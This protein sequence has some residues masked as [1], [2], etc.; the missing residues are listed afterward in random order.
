MNASHWFAAFVA[1]VL[2]E[3]AVAVPLLGRGE[4]LARRA[5]AAFVG[6]LVT[7]PLVWFVWPALGLPRL[8]FLLLGETWALLAELGVYRLVF[9]SLPWARAL[10]VSALANGASCAAAALLAP[11]IR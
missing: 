7:H 8:P 9:P 11:L 10:A 6:Q 4:S 5:G 1:T 3:L 2:I